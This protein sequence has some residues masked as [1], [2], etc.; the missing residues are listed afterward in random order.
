VP[1]ESLRLVQIS[2]SL[3][4]HAYL[5]LCAQLGD[6]TLARAEA[7]AVAPSLRSFSRDPKAYAQMREHLAARIEGLL[8]ARKLGAR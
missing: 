6:P 5:S 2:R 3:A 4:D 1:V 7:R 8:S